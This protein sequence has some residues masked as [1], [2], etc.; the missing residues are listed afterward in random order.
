M[1]SDSRPRLRRQPQLS[2]RQEYGEFILQRI[3]EFKDQ[4][5]RDELLRI[6]DEAVQE[7]EVDADQQ[8]VLTEVLV[9]EHVD[10][11]IMNRLN[12]PPFRR[13]RTK[14]LK[15]REAQR[16]PT[17]WG[18][19]PSTP[20][21]LYGRTLNIEGEALV[22]GGTAG[23]IALYLAAHDWPVV[24]IDP[25]LAVVEAVETRA[26]V[27][28]LSRDFRTLVVAIGGWF[29]DM[30][31][32]FA[33]IDA[34]TLVRMEAEARDGFLSA[35]RTRTPRGGVHCLMPTVADDEVIELSSEAVKA[36][37]DGWHIE[38]GNVGNVGTWFVARSP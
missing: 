38:S 21:A 1:L 11:L 4:L 22:V 5:S 25:E 9:L 30:S 2:L 7:L 17:H 24:F 19:D 16:E 8:L 27:E 13:W 20:A 6:A 37:Y 23:P 26:A 18:L 12:L 14:H 3:E 10:R 33:V 29:P 28:A 31:P 36:H 34:R 32:G 15:L 35:L